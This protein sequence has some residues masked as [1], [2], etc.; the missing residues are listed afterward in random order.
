M[1]VESDEDPALRAASER[2]QEAKPVLTTCS[3]AIA[4]CA[5]N[6]LVIF[7]LGS[8]AIRPSEKLETLR[9]FVWMSL[10]FLPLVA[11]GAASVFSLDRKSIA[12][13]LVCACALVLLNFQLLDLFA[14]IG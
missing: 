10:L 13:L 8:S 3:I 6:A 4:M 2:K 12:V 9:L 14:S 7:A 11:L 5:L 1:N